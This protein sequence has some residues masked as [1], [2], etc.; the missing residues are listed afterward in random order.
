MQGGI[1]LLAL[2]RHEAAVAAGFGLG[3]HGGLQPPEEAGAARH[4]KRARLAAGV[5]TLGEPGLH[6]AAERSG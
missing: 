5:G 3:R 1:F 2:A 4:G 6:F